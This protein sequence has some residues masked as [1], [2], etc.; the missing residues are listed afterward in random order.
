MASLFPKF[1]NGKSVLQNNWK[2]NMLIG[3]LDENKTRT[4]GF[5]F[6]FHKIFNIT[7]VAQFASTKA[8]NRLFPHTCMEIYQ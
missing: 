8:C 2:M 7:H 3:Y 4:G 6:C 1:A 5:R